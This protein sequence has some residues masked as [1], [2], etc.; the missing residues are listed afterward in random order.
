MTAR[1]GAVA[2]EMA[3]VLPVLLVLFVGAVDWG[4]FFVQEATVVVIARDA[5]HAGALSAD[6]PADRARARARG[7]L[8]AHGP[9]LADGD[10]SVVVS[11]E[12][13][14]SVVEVSISVP[15]SPIIGLVPMP[16]HLAAATAMRVEGS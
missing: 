14:G 2:V 5:A 4:W 13:V 10:I 12:P 11:D 15:F 3:L 16:S 7:A 1:R 8:E 6:A 9:S